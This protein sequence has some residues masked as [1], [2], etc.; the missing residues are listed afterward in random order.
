M[1]SRETENVMPATE[2]VAV[3][4][5]LSTARAF[6]TVEVRISGSSTP[7][8]MDRSTASISSPSTTPKS[9]P[10]IGTTN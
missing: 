5:V 6:S 8:P 7:V 9:T 1:I 4:M 3:A 10:N 2:I